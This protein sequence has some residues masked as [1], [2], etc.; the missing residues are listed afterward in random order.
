[1]V[2]DIYPLSLS[3]SRN[4]DS[5]L[6]TPMS[7]DLDAAFTRSATHDSDSTGTPGGDQNEPRDATELP[8]PR[9]PE[10]HKHALGPAQRAGRRYRIWGAHSL[11]GNEPPR[12]PRSHAEPRSLQ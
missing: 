1:L 5:T 7:R 8:E 9:E 6:T 10:R 11:R 3:S 4:S 2:L 12:G